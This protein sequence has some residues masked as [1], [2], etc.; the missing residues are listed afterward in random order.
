MAITQH[1]LEKL[2]H[3]TLCPTTTITATGNQTGVDIRA[4][5]GDLQVIL[6]GTAAGS[7]TDLTFRLEESADDTTYVAV[8][9]GTFTAIGNAAYK[10]VKTFNASDSDAS[11]LLAMKKAE[12]LQD[13]DPVVITEDTT[14]VLR[15]P[16]ARKG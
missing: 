6:V 13:P 9:G 8:T 11:T 16:R 4:L 5:D 12:L 14:P 2:S 3:F 15:K 1:T 7:A 10:E